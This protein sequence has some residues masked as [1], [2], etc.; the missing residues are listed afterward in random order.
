MFNIDLVILKN[1]E[2]CFFNLVFI[3]LQVIKALL[4]LNLILSS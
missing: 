3:Y 1:H 2:F 4:Q